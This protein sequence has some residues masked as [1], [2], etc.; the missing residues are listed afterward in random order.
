MNII[1]LYY[2]PNKLKYEGQMENQ[3]CN[4]Y[5]KLYDTNGELLYDG[6][7]VNNMSHGEGVSYKKQT[8]CI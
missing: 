1:K 3:M 4:G 6:Q 5:G 8:C 2:E 7:W